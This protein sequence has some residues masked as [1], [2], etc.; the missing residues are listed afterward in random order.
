MTYPVLMS[1]VASRLW[2]QFFTEKDKYSLKKWLIADLWHKIRC[3]IETWKFLSYHKEKKL[4]KTARI[5]SKRMK[6]PSWLDSTWPKW[7]NWQSKRTI[8]TIHWDTSRRF[9]FSDFIMTLKKG[10]KFNGCLWRMLGNQL[11]I[12]K[13]SN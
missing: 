12:L 10:T 5:T 4:P 7:S 8:T 6:V 11:I 13:N 2:I 1:L 9:E 3:T